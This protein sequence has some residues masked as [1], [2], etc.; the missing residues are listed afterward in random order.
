MIKY[1]ILLLAFLVI[2][3]D[4]S[5]SVGGDKTE[6]GNFMKGTVVDVNNK[7]I[8]DEMAIL[9]KK[10][11]QPVKNIFNPI[12]T[13]RL[14][15]KGNYSFYINEDGKYFVSLSINDTL[16]TVS[17]TISIELIDGLI[18]TTKTNQ[19]IK[20]DF[21]SISTISTETIDTLEV[22]S[23]DSTDSTEIS[24][25]QNIAG[26]LIDPRNGQ[27]YNY[28]II[29][30]KTWTTQ[31][32]TY[33]R[34]HVDEGLNGMG[35]FI[36]ESIYHPKYDWEAD[37]GDT[38]ETN[39]TNGYYYAWSTMMMFYDDSTKTEDEMMAD[40]K[41]CPEHW[42]LPTIED[43]DSLA[44]SLGIVR[45]SVSPTDDRYPGLGK[46]LKS[47]YG[48]ANSNGNDSLGFSVYPSGMVPYGDSIPVL[49]G[50]DAFYITDTKAE[51]VMSSIVL[52]FSSE[53][54]DVVRE[55]LSYNNLY[56]ARCVKD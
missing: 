7:P 2:F 26:T 49:A 3:C 4:H 28:I 38:L 52:R 42:H 39:Y 47:K 48:W 8:A 43:W 45:D 21:D 10:K 37:N 19:I 20:I 12:D 13:T 11:K 25:I 44:L 6:S 46:L 41:F 9:F 29:D 53:H 32:V 56:S 22:D 27:E 1:I 14:D 15:E 18:D 36:G 51:G 5:P 40:S 24:P 34:T 33:Y 54:D 31:N 35:S 23:A 16:Y 17:D 30:G 55:A 50:T